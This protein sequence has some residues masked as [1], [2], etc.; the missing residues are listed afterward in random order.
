MTQPSAPKTKL[1]ARLDERFIAPVRNAS[2]AR[3][4]WFSVTV[5]A[6]VFAHAALLAVLLWRDR[7]DAVLQAKLEETPVEVV[8]EQPKAQPPAPQL[9]AAKPP[10]EKPATSAPRA[11]ND[12]TVDKQAEDKDTHAPKAPSPA[13]AVPPEQSDAR[14]Q[15]DK[16]QPDRPD[17]E[18][19]DA[20][21]KPDLPKP[22]DTLKKDAEALDKLTPPEPPK[23]PKLAQAKP[24]KPHPK[25][26]LQQ[27]AGSSDLPDYTFAKPMK[28]R[29][30][31]T[32]GTEDDR[33]LAVVYGMIT[34]QHRQISLPDGAWSV[35]V[36]FQ[37]DGHGQLVGVQV[38]Q[39]SG[40]REVDMA[41]VEAV[42]SA[43]PFPPPPSG[44]VTGLVARLRSSTDPRAMMAGQQ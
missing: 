11:P 13:A 1:T 16:A 2:F 14:A 37:V 32:G 39:R 34:Q 43:A 35:A 29:A 12:E 38:T 25:T 6:I 22:D 8:V 21:A 7:D 41:A 19:A 40:Y 17:P 33:Y 28:K 10:I 26:A 9:A 27:L 4:T 36:S 20:E 31:V 5:A 3:R 18:K 42:E 24:V 15:P 23:R 44:A 30:R